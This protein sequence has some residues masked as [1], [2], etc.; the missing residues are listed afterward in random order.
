MTIAL[1][2]RRAIRGNLPQGTS[3][4]VRQFEILEHDLDE[5]LERHVGFVIIDPWPITGAAVAFALT[6]LAGFAD[7]LS[8]PCVTITLADPRSIFAVNEAVFFNPA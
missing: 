5:F 1:A 8:R 6:F 3:F 2:L 4:E 7:H